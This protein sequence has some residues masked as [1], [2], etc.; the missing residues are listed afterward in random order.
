MLENAHTKYS[1]Q[2]KK[3]IFTYFA[4]FC[5]FGNKPTSLIVIFDVFEIA[6][7]LVN[8]WNV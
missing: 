2:N 5:A 3:C 1:L 4:L 8:L 7:V 6:S